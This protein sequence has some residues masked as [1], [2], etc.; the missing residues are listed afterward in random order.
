[1]EPIVMN[2]GSAEGGSGYLPLWQNEDGTW[3][4]SVD[5]ESV[6][7]DINAMAGGSLDQVAGLLV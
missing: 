7:S 3:G 6:D 5:G 4:R 2:G 1:M